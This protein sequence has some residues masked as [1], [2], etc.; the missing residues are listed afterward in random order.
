MRDIQHMEKHITIKEIARMAGV[1][2][3]TVDRVIHDRGRVSKEARAAVEQTLAKVD[4]RPDARALARPDKKKYRILATMPPS[5]TGEYWG[6]I[7][8]GIVRCIREYSDLML[9]CE[10]S[11]YN[12]FDIYSCRSAF[13]NIIDQAPDAVLIGPTFA[14]ET[15]KLCESLDSRQIP[16]VFMDSTIDGTSPV[17]SFA[18]DQYACG[19]LLGE[20]TDMITPEDGRIALFRPERTG[21][22]A[23]INSNEKRRGFFNYFKQNGKGDKLVSEHMFSVPNLKETESQTLEFIR[24]NPSVKGIAVT[25]SRGYI[26]AD[27]LQKCGA[28]HVKV[29]TFDLTANNI[30]CIKNG[31][32]AA[33]LCQ[34]PEQQGYKAAKSAIKWLLYRQKDENAQHLMPLDIV[35]KT[36]LPFYVESQDV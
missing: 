22:E 14:S 30:R 12:Q 34:R 8:S 24:S 17:A 33:I 27:I 10:Y 20:M 4:Y 25:N 28:G 1:S 7:H 5:V 6:A 9:E 31:S 23:S 2:T 18:A 3:G 11:Y 16:Y 36:N 32:V 29:V 35:I 13:E 26:M 15:K 21:N 19:Y